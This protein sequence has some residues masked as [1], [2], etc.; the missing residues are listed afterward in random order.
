M[1]KNLIK[2]QTV[3]NKIEWSFKPIFKNNL[4]DVVSHL[5]QH[6]IFEKSQDSLNLL[7]TDK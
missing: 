6:S 3:R 4:I 1:S 2:S 7:E 5:D